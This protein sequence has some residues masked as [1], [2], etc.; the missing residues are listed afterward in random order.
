M[1]NVSA[2]FLIAYNLNLKKPIMIRVTNMPCING[3]FQEKKERL[4]IMHT[5]RGS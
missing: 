3:G 4:Q 1:S 2:I 5:R